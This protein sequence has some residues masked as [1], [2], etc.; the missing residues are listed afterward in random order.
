MW[1]VDKF[2]GITPVQEN[3]VK[4]VLNDILGNQVKDVYSLTQQVKALIDPDDA[5]E[6]LQ[7]E[8]TKLKK[9]LNRTKNDL[10]DVRAEKV[11]ELQ[12]V[13]HLVKIKKEQLEIAF[14][15][16]TL[17]MQSEMKD[18]E[19]KLQEK[20]HSDI[21]KRLDE[22]ADDMAAVHTRILESLPNLNSIVRVNSRAGGPDCIIEEVKDE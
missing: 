10:A 17:V 14:T 8:I 21:V 13:E 1:L 12:E 6:K 19:F 4:E 5:P 7:R 20:Y 16:K 18:K 3:S 9:E 11:R 2:F 22:Q 15:K